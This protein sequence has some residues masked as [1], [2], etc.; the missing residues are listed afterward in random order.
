[1]SP[2]ALIAA[3]R[4]AHISRCATGLALAVAAA[5]PAHGG[6]PPPPPDWVLAAAHAAIPDYPKATKA[7]V[8]D[9]INAA[10]CYRASSG[11]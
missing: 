6:N 2:R 11:R 3:H 9:K 1:M 10:P 4:P 7:V 8:L 5:L